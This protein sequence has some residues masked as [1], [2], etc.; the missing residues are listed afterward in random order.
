V[1]PAV[2]PADQ[3]V[4]L[5]PGDS[6]EACRELAVAGGWKAY[7]HRKSNHTERPNTCWGIKDVGIVT[8]K[9]IDDKQQVHAIGCTDM[10]RSID[11]NC[12]YDVKRGH[13]VIGSRYVELG[14]GK[15]MDDCRKLAESHSSSPKAFGHRSKD[16]P[17]HPN[18]CWGITGDVVSKN[19]LSYDNHSVGCT[20][21]G[22]TL[23]GG[24]V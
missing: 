13:H 2:N 14:A 4:E 20:K 3:Y 22:K 1:V 15:S 24:C 19:I 16:H 9:L 23:S 5:G 6:M 10:G 21:V 7:G 8:H 18:S 17:A 11:D 12:G